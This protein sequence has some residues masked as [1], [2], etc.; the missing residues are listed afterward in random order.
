MTWTQ[1]AA[2]VFDLPEMARVLPPPRAKPERPNLN[3]DHHPILA[4]GAGR[5][6]RH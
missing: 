1:T 5:F 3:S 2:E 4:V 6:P